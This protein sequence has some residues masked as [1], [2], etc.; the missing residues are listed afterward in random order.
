MQIKRRKTTV[1]TK[2]GIV[3]GG[4]NPIS[5]QSMTNTKTADVK[6]TLA[7][8]KEL[9]KA[10][11]EIIRVA[12]PDSDAAKV[13]GEIKAGIG[14]PLVADIHFNY[15]L[16][17]LSMEQGVDCIRINPGNIKNKDNVREIVLM[18]KDKKIPIRIGLNSGS[19]ERKENSTIVD[20]M[21]SSAVEYIDF[22]E[23]LSFKD[24]VISLKASN[25]LDTIGAY[26]K[27]AGLCEY[28]FHIGITS[29]GDF[30]NGAI[31]SSVG[32]GSLLL[33]GIGDTIR[34]SLTSDPVKE[35]GVAYEILSVLGL[36]KKKGYEIISCP[37]CGRCS[38]DL[39][40][41][42]DKIKSKLKDTDTSL[43][44]AVMGCM[45]NGPG[46]AK[47]VDIGLAWGNKN[48]ALLFKQGEAEKK[49]EG[50]AEEIV[51]EFSDE[52]NKLED[53]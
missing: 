38:V 25:V 16:A 49:L 34:V 17:L 41:I 36:R 48:C 3:V 20:D 27:M 47:D 22:F 19:V 10:G 44:I 24:I 32:L 9:E 15:K 11:C 52:V 51:E 5:V 43:K 6:A 1:I 42:I 50:S 21:V 13:L 39:I 45:V 23:K 14:I 18:A 28:P 8:I 26:R 30:F 31:R 33:E 29:A 53:K 12:V 35:I 2:G 37:T 40:K 7:Q 46:E 4:D